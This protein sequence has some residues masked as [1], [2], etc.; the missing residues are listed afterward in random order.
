MMAKIIDIERVSEES[1]VSLAKTPKK[2]SAVKPSA[3]F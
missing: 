3:P 2:S 1:T